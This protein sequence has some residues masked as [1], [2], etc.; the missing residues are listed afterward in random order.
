MEQVP[1]KRIGRALLRGLAA[2]RDP[3]DLSCEAE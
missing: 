1:E 3:L 2:F